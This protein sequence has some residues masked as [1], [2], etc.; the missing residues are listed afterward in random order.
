MRSYSKSHFSAFGFHKPQII[1]HISYIIYAFSLSTLI[2]TA[3]P[4]A[5]LLVPSQYPTIQAGINA[6]AVSGDTVLVA[7]GTYT[8]NGNRDCDFLGKTLVA[9]SQNG[10]S[11]CIIDCQNA[12]RGFYFHRNEQHSSI[13]TGFTITNGD[14]FQGGA[15][16]IENSA[17]TIDNCVITGCYAM[18]GGGI[19][20]DF[21]SSP[22]I[23]SCIISG[24]TSGAGGGINCYGPN[25]ATIINCIIEMN[26]SQ[27]S[28]G[29]IYLIE[30]NPLILDCVIDRNTAEDE[31]GG[32]LCGVFSD[33]QI[34]KSYIT[35]NIAGAF[36]GGGVY[37]FKL[38]SPVFISTV[39]S[40]NSAGVWD[41]GGINATETELE[42]YDCLVSN[43]SADQGGGIFIGQTS[44]PI[45]E[46]CTIV[47]NSALTH[48][49][50]MVG[51]AFS[52]CTVLNTIIA[53]NTGN[54]GIHF[55]Y[56]T[57]AYLTYNDFFNNQAAPVTGNIPVGIGIICMVNANGDSC[58]SY[59][60]IFLDPLFYSTAGD[61]A[62][63][64]T[65]NSPCI[66][67]G[68]PQS[69]PDPDNT[70]AD[71]G[72]FY[73]DQSFQI[74]V[75]DDLT[76]TVQGDDICLQ[77]SPFTFVTSY[78]IYRSETPYFDITVMTPIASVTD[79]LYIDQ[80][81]VLQTQYF[82]KVTCVTPQ[83][84]YMRLP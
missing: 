81:A 59:Y 25:G 4:A 58:D 54:G 2:I 82:Y 39:I 75:V 66:D 27:S 51:G 43:N 26:V 50:G 46:N 38:S 1:Y 74:P 44:T 67:A 12:G 30:A 64:L 10:P 17:P 79:P 22:I 63:Y 33:P 62:Y 73:Y 42:M 24:N 36:G 41:G 16:L 31:G 61:S 23:S 53:N 5:T 32:I 55:Q 84:Y 29:G 45:I 77:W 71:M 15:V 68:N 60:N 76:I 19:C 49:G 69:A 47:N 40:G 21:Y 8:G 9:A 6:A 80:N 56:S 11:G 34:E 70:I 3:S 72:A 83:A 13:L 37:C 65:E 48:G 78:N 57:A 35:D 7:D 28:G 14:A 18:G 52:Y 20:S